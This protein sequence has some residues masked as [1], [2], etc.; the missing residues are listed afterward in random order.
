LAE[1]LKKGPVV[2][3]FFKIACPVCQ[4]TFPFIER[5]FNA[6]GG[7][8]VTF[9]GISQDDAEATREFC[10]E[11]GV[12]FPTLVDPEDYPA[13]NEYGLTNV[14]T[15]YLISPQGKVEIASVGFT[16][17]ALEQIS[18]RLAR[19]LRRPTVPVFLPGEII[20]ESKPG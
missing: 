9:L 13:S 11:Y 3:A 6:Y 4:F 15:Y 1:A 18:E 5:L 12:T 19:F 20:P 2:A 17:N 14:P 8:R 16:K 7:D 10:E